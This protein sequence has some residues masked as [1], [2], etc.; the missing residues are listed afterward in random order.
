MEL[1]RAR[2]SPHL[3]TAVVMVTASTLAVSGFLIA[4]NRAETA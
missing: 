3:S 4:D 2:L 1:L